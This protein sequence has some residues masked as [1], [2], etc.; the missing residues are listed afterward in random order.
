M[1]G[2]ADSYWAGFNDN[3][4]IITGFVLKIYGS[5]V[6]G[7]IKRQTVVTSSSPEVEYFPLPMYAKEII[8]VLKLPVEHQFITIRFCPRFIVHY[9][10][11]NECDR[12]G[13]VNIQPLRADGRMR[14]KRDPSSKER[15]PRL[16]WWNS[17]W[18]IAQSMTLYGPN[19][20]SC[21]PMALV[22]C[23]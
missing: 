6:C 4:K 23:A 9:T 11:R 2:Y 13:Y 19:F 12:W 22:I 10:G 20:S 17:S 3:W 7:K 5:P 15:T 16:F 21:T 8:L 14:R 18:S 1:Q